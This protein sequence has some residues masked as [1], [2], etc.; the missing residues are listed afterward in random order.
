MTLLTAHPSFLHTKTVI[1]LFVQ[2]VT[3]K[4]DICFSTQCLWKGKPSLANLSPNTPPWG[5]WGRRRW[6]SK[7]S[8]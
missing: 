3:V 8:H 4:Q 6:H 2:N 7:M 1:A 5:A